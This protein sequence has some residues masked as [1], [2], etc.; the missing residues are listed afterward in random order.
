MVENT[1]DTGPVIATVRPRTSF[2]SQVVTLVAVAGPPLGVLS[3]MGILWGVGF[4]AAALVSLVV[5]YTLCGLGVTVGFH[6]LFSHSSF[7]CGSGVRAFWAIA[8]CMAMQGPLTQWVTDHRKHHALSDDD[9]D[10]H[11]PHGHGEGPLG[12]VKG[13]A[14]AH[15]GWLFR[16][17]GME[18][19]VRYGRD[20]Y[21]DRLV[22]RI[23]R[24]Y[25]LWVATTLGIPFL[26]G[27]AWGGG[28]VPLGLECMVWGGVLR[29]FLFQHVTWSIN[30][31]CH[32]FG[33]RTYRTRDESRNVRLLALP[34][35]GESWHNSHHAFPASAVHGMDPRQIDL[36][37]LVITG[38]EKIGLVWDVRRPTDTQRARR[39]SDPQTAGSV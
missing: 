34:S 13:F 24:A 10:P 23:D 3:A 21:G 29:I 7:A 2:S 36:S 30:S 14:H 4:G 16:T 32:M 25:L 26:I 5:M 11:S 18:R 8:G 6:R 27:Y 17:K 37:H 39:R 38:M 1:I 28:S 33:E 22:R 19:G 31:V 15:V 9:G 12:V 20:L 35:F